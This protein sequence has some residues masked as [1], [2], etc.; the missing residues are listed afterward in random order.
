MSPDLFIS[1][2]DVLATKIRQDKT[3][4]GIMIFG[5]FCDSLSFAQNLI[6]IVNDFA[7]FSGLKVNTSKTKAIWLGPFNNYSPNIHR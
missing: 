7:S 2:A 3:V 1:A 4:S 6:G 5:S